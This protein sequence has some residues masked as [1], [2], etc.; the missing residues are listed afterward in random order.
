MVQFEKIIK[1]YKKKWDTTLIL[2][3][4][5]HNWMETQSRFIAMV[6]SLGLIFD[7]GSDVKL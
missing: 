6:S 4:S 5:Q 7:D 2:C 3:A 1:F